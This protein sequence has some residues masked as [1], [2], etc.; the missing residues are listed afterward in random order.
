MLD[1]YEILGI[2]ELRKAYVR[3]KDLK[4]AARSPVEP[5]GPG[6]N[7]TTAV[8]VA[9]DSP[10]T[11][12][13]ISSE[14]ARLNGLSPS[15]L[16]TD[17]V[18]VLKK[19]MVNFTVSI[20]ATDR[21]GDLFLPSQATAVKSPAPSMYVHLTIR[22]TADRTLDKLAALVM[23]RVEISQPGLDAA[24]YQ[25]LVEGVPS[26]GL[27]IGSYQFNLAN[28]LV[29]MTLEETI[30]SRLPKDRYLITSSGK[31]TLGSIQFR[32]WQDGGVLIASGKFP[33]D[34]VLVFLREVV[35]GLDLENLQIFRG[36]TS[37]ISYVLP[38]AERDFTR[39]LELMQSRSS[40]ISIRPDESR[41]LIQKMGD[42]G[43]GSPYVAR[44]MLGVMKIR[45]AVW[46]D[47]SGRN[48]F[49]AKY[50][51]ILS[52]I[53]SAR[54]SGREIQ[55]AW[56]LHQ[57]EVGSGVSVRAAGRHVHV[58]K[59]IDRQLKRELES[60]LNVSARTLK[61]SLQSLAKDLGIDFG[62]L[63]ARESTF[64]AGIARVSSHDAMLSSYL[65]SVR[66]WSEPL[67]LLRNDL[68]HGVIPSPRV[69]YS[70]E[71]LPVRV[72]EPQ[73]AG[74]P[75]TQFVSETLDK[76]CCLVEEMTIFCL[77]R[78]LPKGLEISE[79]APVN[80]T[81]DAPERFRLTV[82][83]GGLPAWTMAPHTKGFL[84][85]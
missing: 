28:E 14:M 53:T 69:T 32:E 48:H 16:W 27:L 70:I 36:P 57:V 83:P 82:S 29:P 54:E 37:Q 85:S 75:L 33:L 10:L 20:P 3:V 56:D 13:Q 55:K 18:A 79:V 25:R 42:E 15:Y 52:G 59:S 45:D 40:N 77:Q 2:E 63:F 68:E 4:S 24:K 34:I 30:A 76:V 17:C 47:E 67:M 65:I 8:V 35:P 66:A 21:S 72:F 23:K 46:P 11:L 61:T 50:D 62:F 43:T 58:D 44:L 78:N 26:N 9:R 19:G 80:R 12:E 60:F 84:G 71:T 74:Q 1:C 7:M 22:A 41:I 49:D 39:A 64:Q 38:V 31:E 6:S 73:F 5:A 81:A 51:P